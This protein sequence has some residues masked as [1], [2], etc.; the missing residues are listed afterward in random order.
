MRRTRSAWAV[1]LAATALAVVAAPAKGQARPTEAVVPLHPE[2][3][4]SVL[5]ARLRRELGLFPELDGFV[6]ATLL[7]P[8]DASGWVLEIVRREQG[9]T[10][11]ERL[12]LSETDLANLRARIGGALDARGVGSVM[13]RE[14][15]GGVV[16]G[17]TLLGL[18]FYGWAV[19]DALGVDGRRGRVAGYLLTSGASFLVPYLITRS[20]SVSR[21]ESDATLW[22]ATRGVALGAVVGDLF[23]LGS[24]DEKR[25]RAAEGGGALGSILVGIAGYWYGG[26][27]DGLVGRTALA[28]AL[29]D[30]ALAGGFATAYALGLYD[31]E[32]TC[33][34]DVCS[35]QDPEATRGGHGLGLALSSAGIAA[36][37]LHARGR[38]VGPGDVRALQS[39]GLLGAQLVAPLAWSLFHDEE[40]AFAGALVLGSA[41]GLW[42]GQRSAMSGELTPGDGLLVLAGHLAGGAGAL[43]LTYLLDD[44]G[45]D[46]TVYLTDRKSVV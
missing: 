32:T 15:R 11:R 28:G 39:A 41:T 16:L 26:T 23:A 5:D 33:R 20:R 29:S 30:F 19:P 25:R 44:G 17:G 2:R 21:A 14:G 35:T 4:I 8:R 37:A 36:A 13:E 10:L 31:G 22:G 3:G 40:R 42:V 38:E 7:R 45:R 1:A 27:V 6:S 43:G 46:P 34:E 24:S 9:E 12:A 18:G